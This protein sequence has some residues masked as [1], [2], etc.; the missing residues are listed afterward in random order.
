MVSI[1]TNAKSLATLLKK[2]ERL[3]KQVRTLN[4]E[5][6]KQQGKLNTAFDKLGL[7]TNFS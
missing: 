4:E 1:E 7:D 6:T 5:I 2:K 3:E